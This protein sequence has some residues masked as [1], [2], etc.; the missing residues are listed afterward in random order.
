MSYPLGPVH[1]RYRVS[2]DMHGAIVEE[3]RWHVIKE[4]DSGYWINPEGCGLAKL[5]HVTKFVL[6]QSRRRY[7]YPDRQ[8]AW[9]SFCIRRRKYERHLA[10]RALC[11]A[12]LVATLPDTVPDREGLTGSG[13]VR[14]DSPK[15]Y[16]APVPDEQVAKH[17]NIPIDWLNNPP[18]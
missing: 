17:Y 11:N 12:A 15:V 13:F 5:P 6:K 4:T 16:E 9:N 2:Y 10:W 14:R 7:A 3:E 18:L 8:E 1:Y